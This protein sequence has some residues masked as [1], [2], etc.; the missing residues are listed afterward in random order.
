MIIALD[1]LYVAHDWTFLPGE[2]SLFSDILCDE[3]VIV[4]LIGFVAQED[5]EVGV[6]ALG[7]REEEFFTEFCYV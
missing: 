2:A 6:C 4:I 7:P 1:P 3:S 5:A